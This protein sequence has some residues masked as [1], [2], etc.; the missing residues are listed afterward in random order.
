MLRG[1]VSGFW[2]LGALLL[3]FRVQVSGQV[4]CIF[5]IVFGVAIHHPKP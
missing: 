4:N 2:G 1:A 3:D 5:K